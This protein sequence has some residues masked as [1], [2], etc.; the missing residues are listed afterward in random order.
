MRRRIAHVW[1][2]DGSGSKALAVVSCALALLAAHPLAAQVLKERGNAELVAVGMPAKTATTVIAPNEEMSDGS[3]ESRAGVRVKTLRAGGKIGGETSVG[4]GR[5]GMLLHLQRLGALIVKEL[6]P[7][8]GE[9]G[10]DHGPCLAERIDIANILPRPA[11]AYRGAEAPVPLDS[12]R[13]FA[14]AR[15]LLAP[16]TAL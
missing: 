13:T 8:F 11:V 12:A 16:P 6:A 4:E 9:R 1:K 7:A 5:D 3:G 14:I 15:L 10:L 2:Y